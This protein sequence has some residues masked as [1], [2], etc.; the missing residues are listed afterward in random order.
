MPDKPPQFNPSPSAINGD[1]ILLARISA[2]E[3]RLAVL[4]QVIKVGPEGVTINS[5]GGLK[6]SATKDCMVA[7]EGQLAI[8]SKRSLEI[9]TIGS[10]LLQSSGILLQCQSSTID[11]G[12]G[13]NIKIHGTKVD[14]QGSSDVVLKGFKATQN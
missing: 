13:G 1:A 14:V 5:R 4:E 11:M 3:A 10:S 8:G 12:D 2:L 6:I 7:V 9:R